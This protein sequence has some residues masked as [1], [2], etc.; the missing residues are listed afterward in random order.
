MLL[1]SGNDF[2][3]LL[4]QTFSNEHSLAYYHRGPNCSCYFC[5]PRL[6]RPC[7]SLTRVLE[8]RARC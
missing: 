3:A 8:I 6:S 2:V 4:E 5:R 1:L 7:Y